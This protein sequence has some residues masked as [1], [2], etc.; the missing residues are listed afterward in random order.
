M[1][2]YFY[3]AARWDHRSEE[4]RTLV[5]EYRDPTVREILSRLAAECDVLARRAEECGS[6]DQESD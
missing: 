1:T 4:I 5:E 6:C 2:P 3:S